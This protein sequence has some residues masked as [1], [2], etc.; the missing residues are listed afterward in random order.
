MDCHMCWTMPKRRESLTKKLAK[1]VFPLACKLYAL[2]HIIVGARLFIDSKAQLTLLGTE[3]DFVES[4]LSSEFVF[5]NPNIT[6][7]CGCGESFNV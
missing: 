3:M 5:H 6:G 2:P 1:T 4:K 7:T